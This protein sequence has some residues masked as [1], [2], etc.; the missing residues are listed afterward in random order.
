LPLSIVL[1]LLPGVVTLAIYLMMGPFVRG[2][3]HPEELGRYVLALPLGVIALE[4]G[5]MFTVGRRQSGRLSLQ[6]VILYRQSMPLWQYGALGLVLLVWNAIIYLP[7]QQVTSEWL[8]STVFAWVPVWFSAEGDY[9]TYPLTGLLAI[10]AVFVV[11]GGVA[12][13]VEELYFRGYLLPRLSRFLW[14]SPFINALLFS[15][16]HLDMLGSVVAVFLGSLPLAYV[17]Y[18]KKNVTLAIAM[19]AGMNALF[20]LLLFLPLLLK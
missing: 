13:A 4:L 5:I 20:F 14:W 2:L 18:W 12:G 19:H 6:R 11:V 17:A 1:H 7:V 9:S 10:T 3:G 16:Y 15:L 8:N